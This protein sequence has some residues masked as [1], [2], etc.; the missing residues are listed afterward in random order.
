MVDRLFEVGDAPELYELDSWR[1]LPVR[2]PGNE[3]F[4]VVC[5]LFR[6]RVPNS[7][8]NVVPVTSGCKNFWKS[9]SGKSTWT[10][11]ALL[12]KIKLSGNDLELIEFFLLAGELFC[13]FELYDKLQNQQCLPEDEFRLKFFR[14]H[15]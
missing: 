14:T 13:L 7:F 2:H 11:L 15:F 1:F 12:Y 3:Q 6:S 5:R 9:S 4:E 10:L 8:L